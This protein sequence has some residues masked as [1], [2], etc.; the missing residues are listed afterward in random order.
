VVKKRHAELKGKKQ[1]AVLPGG[2]GEVLSRLFD[3]QAA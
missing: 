2:T 3:P 1:A